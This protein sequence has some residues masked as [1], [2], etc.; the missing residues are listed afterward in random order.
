[1]L[2]GEVQRIEPAE[3]VGV[4]TMLRADGPAGGSAKL[5]L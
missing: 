4:E 1:M 3:I 2:H 5:G